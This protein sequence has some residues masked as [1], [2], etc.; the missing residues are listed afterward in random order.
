MSVVVVV[1]SNIVEP[2]PG[3]IVDIVVGALVSSPPPQ[4][5]RKKVLT[6]QG[7]KEVLNWFVWL[8]FA[9]LICLGLLIS[10]VGK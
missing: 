2:R 8:V 3:R 4:R 7:I 5:S 9:C 6:A 1:Y 10:S